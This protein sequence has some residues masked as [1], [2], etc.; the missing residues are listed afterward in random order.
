M[1][2]VVAKRGLEVQTLSHFVP[3]YEILPGVRYGRSDE[4]LSPAY[5]VLRCETAQPHER[6]FL[7]CVGTLEEEVGFCLLGGYGVTAE[8]ATAFFN[9]LKEEGAFVPSI[10]VN[11]SDIFRILSERLS[12]GGK[13]RKYRFPN[14]RSDRL[15]KAMQ[16]LAHVPPATT[17]ALGFRQYLQEIEGIGPKT[18]SWITRNWL[19]SDEVAI[20]D[21]HLLRAGQ[22]INLFDKVVQLPRD[23]RHVEET[24]LDFAARIHVQPSILDAVIWSDMRKFGSRLIR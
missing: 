1:N 18:A 11:R 12:V 13:M 9:R 24:F 8:L 19:G 5:W 7:N 6:N 3:E 4:L 14:Q 23:Y 10:H 15:S 2:H 22:F 20:L 16:Y 21:I 17:D